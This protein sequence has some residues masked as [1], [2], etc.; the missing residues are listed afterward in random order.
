MG[1]SLVREG[2]ARRV[3]R[4]RRERA[5]RLSRF[6][7]RRRV[8]SRRVRGAPDTTINGCSVYESR[9]RLARLA[10][11]HAVTPDLAM[12]TPAVRHPGRD[13]LRGGRRDPSATAWR[14]TRTRGA[15][16]S[17]PRTPSAS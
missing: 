12:P 14:R 3:D 10:Q 6:A 15:R 11:E 9:V 4:D 7:S 13:R 16:Q 17:S 8:R 5:A 2:R 1:A